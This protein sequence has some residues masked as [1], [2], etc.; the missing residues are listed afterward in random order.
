[1]RYKQCKS[2]GCHSNQRIQG[3]YNIIQVKTN[4]VVLFGIICI[5]KMCAGKFVDPLKLTLLPPSGLP[6]DRQVALGTESGA[7]YIFCNFS[8]S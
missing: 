3:V 6:A 8:V 7:I 4:A 1:M 2:N 5:L